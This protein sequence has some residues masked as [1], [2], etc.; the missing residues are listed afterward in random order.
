[1][2]GAAD[3]FG[4]QA[5]EQLIEIPGKPLLHRKMP[6][7][8]HKGCDMETVPIDYLEWLSRTDLDEDMETAFYRDVLFWYS[9]CGSNGF[10]MEAG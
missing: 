5:V 1:V 2:V 3:E 7:D 4:D 8:K 6:F 9:C 10:E